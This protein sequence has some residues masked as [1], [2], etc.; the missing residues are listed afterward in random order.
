MVPSRVVARLTSLDARLAAN[1]LRRVSSYAYVV[2]NC[3][4]DAV[5]YAAA[6]VGRVLDP[7]VSRDRA[8]DAFEQAYA[9]YVQREQ[10]LGEAVNEVLD[11]LPDREVRA[12]VCADAVLAKYSAD[13]SLPNVPQ[14]RCEA[15]AH[16][17]A[18]MRAA[19]PGHRITS[20]RVA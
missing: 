1:G 4:F 19:R 9:A 16:S 6:H 14:T 7:F 11:Q 10:Q 2:G 17:A 8:I 5:Q 3:L 15:V 12:R 18:I 20:R 13:R